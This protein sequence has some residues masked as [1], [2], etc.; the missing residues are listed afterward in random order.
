[1]NVRI[2][3]VATLV[4]A[5]I[6]L[7]GCG[8]SDDDSAGGEA[9]PTPSPSGPIAIPAV[10]E[11]R[12]AA[13]ELV[14]A[15][16]AGDREGIQELASDSLRERIQESDLD[17]LADCIGEGQE[18]QILPGPVTISGNAASVDVTWRITVGE[19]SDEGKRN[20]QYERLADGSWALSALPECPVQPQS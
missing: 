15:I 8:S 16:E 5:F 13:S 6:V 9:T 4:A 18:V 14:E 20:W 7:S 3:I 10:A 2:S 11:L 19:R 12:S 1:M 17:R